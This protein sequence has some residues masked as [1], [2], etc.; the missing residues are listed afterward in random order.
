MRRVAAALAAAAALLCLQ[1]PA[2][3]SPTR[4]A[5][6]QASHTDKGFAEVAGC[7]SGAD[8]LLI[9]V[10]VDESQSLR[11]TDPHNLRVQGITS[12]V[13][14]LE[15]LSQLSG[16]DLNVETSLATFARGY[17]V[18]VDWTRLTPSA[19]ESIRNT[20][21]SELPGR[22]AGNA[23]DY[24]QAL[25]G[26][27]RQLETR[28]QQIG[29]PQ[30]CKVVLWFTDGALD[31]DA[32][33]QSAATEICQQGGIA[34]SVRHAGISVIALALFTPGADVTPAQR[35]QLRAVAEGS[36][37]SASCGSTPI[38][39]DDT[40]GV[41]LPA[42]DPAALQLLFA[43]AGALVA[44]GT[45]GPSST[46]PSAGCPDGTFPL[47]VDQGISGVRVVVQTQGNITLRSPSGK[48]I[49]VVD[50]LSESV[51]GARVL[52]LQRDSL[53]TV[54]LTYSPYA[55]SSANWR[56]QA[57]TGARVETYWFWGA[58]VVP[59]TTEIRA[60]A[61]SRI[62]YRLVDDAGQPLPTSLFRDMNPSIEVDG[63]RLETR[64]APD[65]TVSASFRLPTDD[66]PS[67]LPVRAEISAVSS[68]SGVRLGPTTSVDKLHVTLPPAF[69]TVTP[70]SLDF[71]SLEG[72]GTRS[73][74]L[75][76]SGSAL[77]P[78]RVCLAGSSMQTP[79][80]D[81]STADVRADRKCVEI[82][83]AGNATMRLS[84]SPQVSAD[85]I[86]TG[87]IQLDLESAEGKHA[88]L[89]LPASLQMERTVD[90]AKRWELIA[91]LFL[92]ALLIPALLLVGSNLALGRFSMTSGTRIARV[93]VRITAGGL[94]RRDGTALLAAADLKNVT[95]SGRRRAARMT[96]D[97]TGITLR[98]RRILSLRA[99]LGVASDPGALKLVSG[100]GEREF[101]K[102]RTD[103]P[104]GL[105]EVDATFVAITDRGADGEQARGTLVVVVPAHVDLAGAQAR[106]RQMSSGPDWRRIVDD[107]EPPAEA[108]PRDSR[109]SDQ[110]QRPPT[111]APS[112]TESLPGLPDFL[113]GSPP[114]SPPSGTS[115]RPSTRNRVRDSEPSRP[116]P[117]GP[118]DSDL[119]PLPDFLRDKD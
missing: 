79:G 92:L 119:P 85:G 97:G 5:A 61:T 13:D 11:T 19:A 101:K 91:A 64:V 35:D 82:P 102:V 107:L 89:S 56:L 67:S 115:T 62:V 3:A 29:D 50:G 99:P 117:R 30:A 6:P 32:A 49:D 73:A 47:R 100:T 105:G 43:G 1:Q 70:D 41:Y 53:T 17:N 78:T 40:T 36:G 38:S 72:V 106:A 90:E 8:N 51:D 95:F 27:K 16:R 88:K 114:S 44:G 116:A 103:A 23:T 113:G 69:P 18:L 63:K 59:E 52:A 108:S 2:V 80:H 45:A 83:R 37:E 104:V 74:R 14:S 77:G 21:V 96:V 111:E 46:C 33:T 26:A 7:I 109:P 9:S 20:A 94:D 81:G 12:A 28:A 22:D 4:S 86:A 87:T 66:L 71:G 57:G 54:N 34:D 55:D 68:P 39:A 25:L 75:S 84:W 15:Q 24:R 65:G 76:L 60:G 112:P 58:H 110:T 118:A 48:Q 31:V 98:A 10:V 93:P 42:D